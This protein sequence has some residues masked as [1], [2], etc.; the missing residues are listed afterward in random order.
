MALILL[1]EDNITN[2]ALASVLLAKA[3][4]DVIQ[5]LDAKSG[6]KQSISE[7]PDLILMDV[8]LP[9]ISGLEA[10]AQIKANPETKTI[11][12]IALTAQAMSGDEARCRAAGCDGYIAKPLNYKALWTLIKRQ[13]EKTKAKHDIS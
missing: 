9:G 2:M 12:I 11:P 13:L 8:Q 10:T 3:G 1:V 4:Y 7:S 5:A 6:I